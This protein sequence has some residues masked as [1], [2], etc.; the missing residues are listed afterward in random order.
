[1]SF[2]FNSVKFC[3]VRNYEKLLRRAREV[4]KALEYGKATK[5]ADDI[6]RLCAKTSYTH[7]YQLVEL[8]SEINFVEW[9]MDSRKADYYVN[10]KGMY[11]IVFISQQPKAKD[12][13]KHFCNV[14]FPHFRQQ[15]AKE[16]HQ[17]A[18]KENAAIVFSTIT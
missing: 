3:V 15:L 6:K 12:F 8:V 5:A 13:R 4:C 14:L 16:D 1:M 2:V 11:E 10:G 17:Q 9:P 7:K 18:V